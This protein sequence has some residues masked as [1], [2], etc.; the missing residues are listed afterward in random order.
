[1][2]AMMPMFRMLAWGPFLSWAIASPAEV[3]QFK[4]NV[5]VSSMD[6]AALRVI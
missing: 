3:A 2:W 4:H 1:M 6:N 5:L